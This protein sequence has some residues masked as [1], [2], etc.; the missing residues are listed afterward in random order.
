MEKYRKN[1]K[2]NVTNVTLY[3]RVDVVVY[4]QHN[5]DINHQ[6]YLLFS[7]EKRCERKNDE[8]NERRESDLLQQ[9]QSRAVCDEKQENLSSFF[10]KRRCEISISCYLDE[11]FL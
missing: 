8:K 2:E 11:G 1:G 10:F 9:E 7:E 4:F 6:H 5:S 3:N